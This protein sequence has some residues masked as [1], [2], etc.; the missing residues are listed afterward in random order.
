MT[1]NHIAT[2]IYMLRE[3]RINFMKKNIKPIVLVLAVVMLVATFGMLNIRTDMKD[4]TKYTQGYNVLSYTDSNK[5]ATFM[6]DDSIPKNYREAMCFLNTLDGMGHGW[7][8]LVRLAAFCDESL[9]LYTGESLYA[10]VDLPDEE[11]DSDKYEKNYTRYVSTKNYLD[12]FNSKKYLQAYYAAYRT[13]TTQEE[14]EYWDEACPGWEKWWQENY[15]SDDYVFPFPADSYFAN[16]SYCNRYNP[17]IV[18]IEYGVDETKW[19][20]DLEFI[21][22]VRAGT[23]YFNIGWT[24]STNK[25]NVGYESYCMY[26]VAEKHDFVRVTNCAAYY[27]GSFSCKDQYLMFKDTDGGIMTLAYY[28]I[29]DNYD[30]LLKKGEIYI[31]E[32]GIPWAVPKK[33]DSKYVWP[34]GKDD[35]NDLDSYLTFVINAYPDNNGIKDTKFA[36]KVGKPTPVPTETPAPTAT[37]VPT[38]IPVPTKTPETV[39]TEPTPAGVKITPTAEPEVT[40]TDDTTDG[41]PVTPT[42]TPAPIEY[43]DIPIASYPTSEEPTS[44]PITAEDETDVL[45]AT[46]ATPVPVATQAPAVPEPADNETVPTEKRTEFP[47]DKVIPIVIAAVVVLGLIVGGAVLIKK[48]RR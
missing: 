48:K 28:Y 32:D 40:R 1:Y 33:P 6:E 17:G 16:T 47:T 13:L 18:P 11:W 31:D 29:Q 4:E 20:S 9:V 45:V 23:D 39:D 34:M 37:P 19:S 38:A 27:E 42:L 10:G 43:N 5:F 12:P 30:E 2:G 14:K 25:K 3:E 26:Y 35:P 15:W 41:E 22:A 7:M 46:E 44:A 36:D 24:P 21:R 8:Q